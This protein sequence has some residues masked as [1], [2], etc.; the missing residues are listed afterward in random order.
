MN[1]NIKNEVEAAGY[2]APDGG[3]DL[4][5]I[6]LVELAKNVPGKEEGHKLH[7][8]LGTLFS[9]KVKAEEK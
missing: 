1:T 6:L 2:K 9:R 7:R 5:N 4:I 8:L 3:T